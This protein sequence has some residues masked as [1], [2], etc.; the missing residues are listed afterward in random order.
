MS[1]AMLWRGTIVQQWQR[2]CSM[3]FLCRVKGLNNLAG[4]K[5][6]AA[7]GN[8]GAAVGARIGRP[9]CGAE[10]GCIN[11]ATDHAVGRNW[12]AG[13]GVGAFNVTIVPGRVP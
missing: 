5:A 10:L 6:A 8:Y 12:S 7:P 1:R 9:C 2:E 4:H 3:L 11:C 13:M